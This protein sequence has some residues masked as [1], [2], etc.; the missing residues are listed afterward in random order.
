MTL[1]NRALG[2]GIAVVSFIMQTAAIVIIII[3]LLLYGLS[4]YHSGAD[5]LSCPLLMPSCRLI[6]RITSN[7]RRV[8]FTISPNWKFRCVLNSRKYFLLFDFP[9]RNGLTGGVDDITEFWAALSCVNCQLAQEIL[10][11]Q[12]TDDV[13]GQ[14]CWCQPIKCGRWKGRWH[15]WGQQWIKRWR[16]FKFRIL[17]RVRRNT[18]GA[19]CLNKKG[20]CDEICKF[21]NL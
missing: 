10:E 13:A 1:G 8:L 3:L 21:V 9:L 5:G 6:Y 14:A 17:K 15:Y 7:L 20:R 19:F 4:G 12:K 11:G 2:N 16:Y 18:G